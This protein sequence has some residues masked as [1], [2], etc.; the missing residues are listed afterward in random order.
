MLA[1]THGS[2][3][4]MEQGTG[5]ANI[6]KSL[7]KGVAPKDSP[8]LARLRLNEP[9]ELMLSATFQ[10]AF[11]QGYLFLRKPRSQYMP[12]S[13][14]KRGL[15]SRPYE[16]MPI[17]MPGIDREIRTDHAH[18]SSAS[19]LRASLVNWHMSVV[20]IFPISKRLQLPRVER[21]DIL[22]LLVEVYQCALS[23]Q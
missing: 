20:A 14:T 2:F 23:D 1:S 17:P 16:I 3:C 9:E 19:H 10:F 8:R 21:F 4:N 13:K 15:I 12:P 7:T 11:F 6:W 22:G 18:R 5:C